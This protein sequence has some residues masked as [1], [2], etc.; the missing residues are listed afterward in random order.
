MRS[1]GLIYSYTE[2]DWNVDSI[3]HIEKNKADSNPRH[4]YQASKTLAEKALWSESRHTGSC[5]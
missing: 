5:C 2:K 3:P 1:L 4:A